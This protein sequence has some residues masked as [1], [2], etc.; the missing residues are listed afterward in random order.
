MY[1][2]AFSKQWSGTQQQRASHLLKTHIRRQTIWNLCWGRHPNRVLPAGPLWPWQA[3]PGIIRGVHLPYLSAPGTTPPIHLACW[4]K[5]ELKYPQSCLLSICKSK[6]TG[7][8]TCSLLRNT[9]Q[10]LGEY[11]CRKI[12]GSI[13]HFKGCSSSRFHEI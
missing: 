6:S 9:H 4:L 8:N 2:T 11:E 1:L 5:A 3:T 12:W 7:K 10:P 13:L